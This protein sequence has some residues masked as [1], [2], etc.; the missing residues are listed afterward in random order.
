MSGGVGDELQ[1]DGGTP[2]LGRRLVHRADR[3]VVDGLLASRVHLLRCVRRETDDSLRAEQLPRLGHR[4]VI[5]ADVHAIGIGLQCQVGPVVHHEQDVVLGADHLEA[6]GGTE[7]FV[8]VQVLAAE[9][10][11]IDAALQRRVQERVGPG[12]AYQVEASLGELLLASRH[13][14]S[15][16]R[17]WR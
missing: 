13:A 14:V 9:L 6:L 7:N 11:Q 3:D 4:R 2:G 17:P 8:I 1:A 15:L 5:L 12:I 10:H 16:A